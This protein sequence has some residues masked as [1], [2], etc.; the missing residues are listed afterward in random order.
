ME[1]AMS[2]IIR[3]RRG[4]ASGPAWVAL[5]IATIALIMAILAYNRSGRDIDDAVRDAL[6]NATRTTQD[7]TEDAGNAG[8]NAVD[9][10]EQA[11]DNGPDGQDDGAR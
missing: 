5:L 8:S 3:E 11:V 4:S 10:A 7:A 9:S 6:N 2:E 1:E